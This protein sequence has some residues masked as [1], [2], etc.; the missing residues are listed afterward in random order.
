MKR[1]ARSQLAFNQEA[2]TS[3]PTSKAD[4]MMIIGITAAEN[5]AVNPTT[6]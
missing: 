2:Q 6:L 5:I 1:G 4:P 3:L